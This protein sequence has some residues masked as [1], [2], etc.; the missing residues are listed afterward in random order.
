MSGG[1]AIDRQ[2]ALPSYCYHQSNT[3]ALKSCMCGEVSLSVC[4][5]S[6]CRRGVNV[7]K[8]L[9]KVRTL[10]EQGTLLLL[11]MD[12]GVGMCFFGTD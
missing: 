9:E 4:L 5:P 11:P 10:S 1:K 12:L 8:C 6:G 2:T 3:A 7:G